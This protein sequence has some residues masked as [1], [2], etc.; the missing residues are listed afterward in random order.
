M[1]QTEYCHNLG[2]EQL[3]SPELVTLSPERLYK[4]NQSYPAYNA[5]GEWDDLHDKGELDLIWGCADARLILPANAFY[6]RS[7]AAAGTREPFIPLLQF[8]R[9]VTVVAHYDGETALPGVR[10]NGCGGQDGKAHLEKNGNYDPHVHKGDITEFVHNLVTHEDPVLNAVVTASQIARYTDTPTTALAQDHLTGKNKVLAVYSDRGR[11]VNSCIP[12]EQLIKA[13]TQ[14]NYDPQA[15][16]A[17]GVPALDTGSIPE[18]IAELLE[19][20]ERVLRGINSAIPNLPSY[21]KIQNPHTLLI[22]TDPRPAKVKYPNTFGFPNQVFALRG[23]RM[24][25][26]DRGFQIN[27]PAIAEITQQAQYAVTHALEHAQQPGSSFSTLRNIF[28]ESR[29][30]D[31]SEAIIHSLLSKPWMQD[32][33]ALPH[34]QILSGIIDQGILQDCQKITV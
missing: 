28:V 6:L 29:H 10:P 12:I 8:C 31:S 34:A 4:D 33:L 21:Q 20:K 25:H 15:V 7:I 26:Q 1:P 17:E 24:Y 22:S 30:Q 27:E 9:G 23:P 18:Y 14:N 13:M 2:P 32:F 5:R 11:S 16:Y 3:S 19:R